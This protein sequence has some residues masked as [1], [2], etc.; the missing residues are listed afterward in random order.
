M[1]YFLKTL[2][3]ENGERNVLICKAGDLPPI[4]PNL[5]FAGIFNQAFQTRRRRAQQLVYLLNWSDSAGINL[6][7]R[8]KSGEGLCYAEMTSLNYH[9][10]IR[11]S[12]STKITPYVSRASAAARYRESIKYL[13]FLV[14]RFADSRRE[15]QEYMDKIRSNLSD[16]REVFDEH[17]W[18]DKKTL[19]MGLTDVERQHLLELIATGSPSNPFQ[20]RVRQRNALIVHLLLQTGIR[21]G[22]LLSLR[23][24]C[25]MSEVDIEFGMRHFLRVD[26]N[27]FLDEDPR[28]IP[29]A[30]K[31]NSR[32]IPISEGLAMMIDEF[33]KSGRL[34]RGREAKKAPAFLFL[35]SDQKPKPLSYSALVKMFKRLENVGNADRKV[36]MELYPHRFRYTFFEN[37]VRVSN[38]KPDSEEAKKVLRYLGGWSKTSEQHTLY[39]QKEIQFLSHM[40]LNK[41]HEEYK[42]YS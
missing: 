4:Y 19:R 6:E 28:S 9:L 3:S 12:K 36:F 26:E 23:C 42:T 7:E 29:P 35:S 13:Q 33:I 2:V 40:S 41:L 37:V 20:Q 32:M 21:I 5:Y 34:Y 11:S 8:I 18:R 30:L 27:L 38:A 16:L 1:T 25:C 22:E 14:R 10:C 24:N 39:A 31:T 15:P 17:L